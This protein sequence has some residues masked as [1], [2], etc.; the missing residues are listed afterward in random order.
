MCIEV[1]TKFHELKSL[2]VAEVCRPLGT[3]CQDEEGG[4][5]HGVGQV[6]D[7]KEPDDRHRSPV[8]LESF[9]VLTKAGDDSQDFPHR[10]A[11]IVGRRGHGNRDRSGALHFESVF[12]LQMEIELTTCSKGSQLMLH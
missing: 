9:D 10:E 11:P 1:V 6:E 12:K 3:E 7:G 8:Q 4:S 2:L 5:D